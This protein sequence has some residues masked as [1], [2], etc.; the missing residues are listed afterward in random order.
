MGRW[1]GPLPA[2]IVEI[3]TLRRREALDLVVAAEPLVADWRNTDLGSSDT[4]LDFIGSFNKR[5]QEHVPRV[6]LF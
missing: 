1:S 6:E 4:V 5:A 2:G 3:S